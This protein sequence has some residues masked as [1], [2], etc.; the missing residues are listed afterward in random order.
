MPTVRK[1]RQALGRVV[2]SPDDFGVRVLLDE[3]Y[4]A[5][6][7]AE[8]GDYSVR[9]TFPEEERREHIDVRPGKLKY[10]MLNFYADMD[11][12]AGTPPET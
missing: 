8:L 3:R 10:A 4:T 5:S 2:R 12:W 6:N 11:A 9:D 7:A 1:T